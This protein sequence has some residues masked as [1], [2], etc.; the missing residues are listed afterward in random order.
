M[1]DYNIARALDK[2]W[3]Q[4]DLYCREKYEGKTTRDIHFGWKHDVFG[5]LEFGVQPNGAPFFVHGNH[6]Q[7]YGSKDNDWY[8]HDRHRDGYPYA[9][10]DRMEEIV[11]DWP[12]I[13]KKLEELFQR[14]ESILNFKI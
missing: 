11:A 14:E 5:W 6:S 3:N 2:A 13:K 7:S 8:F 12:I 4:I 1:I 9:K 10:Y